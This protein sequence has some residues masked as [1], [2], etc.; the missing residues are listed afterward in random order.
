MQS[1]PLDT[2][3]REKIRLFKLRR[4]HSALYCRQNLGSR[5]VEQAHPDG[6]TGKHATKPVWVQVQQKHGKHDRPAEA[7]TGEM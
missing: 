5:L 2:K 6:S 3:T 4:H 1:V 7:V